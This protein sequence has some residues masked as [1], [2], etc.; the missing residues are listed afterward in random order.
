MPVLLQPSFAPL[1][2]APVAFLSP[3]FFHAPHGRFSG[4]SRDYGRRMRRW[5]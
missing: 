3:N 5:L 1:P 4:R 2:I